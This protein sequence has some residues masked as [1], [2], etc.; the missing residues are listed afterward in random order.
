[1][2]LTASRVKRSCLPASVRFEAIL[3][4]VGI[5]NVVVQKGKFQGSPDGSLAGLFK[6]NRRQGNDD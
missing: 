4:W 5:A 1:M 6:C 2:R 3:T